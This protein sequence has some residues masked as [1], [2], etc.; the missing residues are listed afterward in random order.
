MLDEAVIETCFMR[1]RD[2]YFFRYSP[3]VPFGVAFAGPSQ[4]FRIDNLQKNE[5]AGALFLVRK[6][7][8]IVG[9]FWGGVAIVIFIA[10]AIWLVAN[11][12]PRGFLLPLIILALAPL[13]LYFRFC[14][15]RTLRP[16][17][18][19]LSPVR[20]RITFAE[21]LKKFAANA[22][23][24]I[25]ILRLTVFTGLS[26]LSLIGLIGVISADRGIA[27][28]IATA[29]LVAAFTVL[30]IYYSCLTVLKATSA[31]PTS[32]SDRMRT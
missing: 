5:I 1:T 19:G 22:P 13:H 15:V 8:R 14:Y 31:I 20:T 11:D 21:R 2:G 23:F 25:L 18:D 17:L 28:L 26:V 7:M 9:G 32:H 6:K 3:W 24:S 30:M 12:Y 10:G 27:N 16:L 4:H 29:V